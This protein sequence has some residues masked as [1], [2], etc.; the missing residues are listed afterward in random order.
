MGVDY[1]TIPPE[2]VQATC[3]AAWYELTEGPLS[4]A[5]VPYDRVTKRSAGGSSETYA[6]AS[7][8]SARPVLFLINDLVAGLLANGTGSLN[9]RLVRG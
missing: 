1:L 9:G 5:I 7:V 8:D 6:S 2:I 3:E 4:P